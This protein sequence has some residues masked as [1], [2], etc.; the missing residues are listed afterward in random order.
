MGLVIAIL[1]FVIIVLMAAIWSSIRGAERI[2][3]R[4]ANRP[5]AL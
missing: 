3:R 4:K 2:R 5:Y 1:A